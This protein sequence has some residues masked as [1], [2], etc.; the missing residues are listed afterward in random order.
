MKE[1]NTNAKIWCFTEQEGY[2]NVPR[3]HLQNQEDW[4]LLRSSA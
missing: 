4:S 3:V 2:E 1:S